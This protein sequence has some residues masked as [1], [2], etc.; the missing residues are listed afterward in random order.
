MDQDR[1]DGEKERIVTAG[2]GHPCTEWF[3]G[4]TSRE[5]QVR[6]KKDKRGIM[7]Q[8]PNEDGA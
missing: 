2:L 7:S 8:K 4:Q 5:K 6:E 1:K 3:R